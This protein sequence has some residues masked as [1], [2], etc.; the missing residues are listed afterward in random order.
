MPVTIALLLAAVQPSEAPRPGASSIVVTGSRTGD[1]PDSRI[2]AD[3]IALRQPVSLIEL[4]DDVAGIRAFSTGGVGGGTY[5]T[6]RGGEPNFTLVAI[7]GLKLNNPM[8]SRGGAFDLALIDPASVEAIDVV[9]GAVSAIHG[10]DA[11]SGLVAIRLRAPRPGESRVA[12][13]FMA[14]SEGE[15]GLGA[16]ASRGWADGGALIAGGWFDSGGLDTGSDLERFQGLARIHQSI[17]GIRAEAVAIAAR[18]ERSVFPEDGGGPLFASSRER[19]RGEAELV[20]GIVALRRLQHA[21][22]RPNLSF[23]WSRQRDDIEA[24]AIAPGALDGVPALSARNLFSRAE[25]IADL[26]IDAGAFTAT[27]GAALLRETGST[28][29]TI[30]I[31]FAVPVEFD[32][33]RTTRSLFAEATVRPARGVSLNVAARLDDVADGPRALTGR[34]ALRFELR[35]GGPVLFAALGQGY[36]LPSF[37]ALGHPL[38][39]NADLRPERSVNAE[40]GFE[41]PFGTGRSL[42]LALFRNRF[43]DL[44]DFDPELFT[45]VNRARVVSSGMEAEAR[46]RVA[47]ELALSGA[48]TFLDL[49]SSAPL[50]GRPRWHGNVRASWRPTASLELAAALR[51]NSGFFDSSIPTSLVRAEGHF[52]AD[53]SLRYR[54]SPSLSLDAALR[55]LTDSRHQ[56]AVGFPAPGRLV[57]ATISASF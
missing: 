36:K 44:V 3:E 53:L 9:R 12:S 51:A 6:V 21:S 10:S 2:E 14:G 39:G 11:L 4:L 13:R 50:R 20:A 22:I 26:G 7:E 40:A 31:G 45:N 41:W 8:N 48:L 54:L 38:I 46:W 15:A 17:G 25:A 43:R 24:P 19:E 1:S 37:F 32:I 30:D 49:E 28:R 33:V 23:S 34:A 42:R 5:L 29:G 35:P 18:I 56:D 52:E 16:N 47:P 55:N 57:R 27:V